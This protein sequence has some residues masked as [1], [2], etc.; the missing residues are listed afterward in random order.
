MNTDSRFY[1]SDEAKGK[2]KHGAPLKNGGF[3]ITFIYRKD[4]KDIVFRSLYLPDV[5]I[6][7][8]REEEIISTSAAS[9]MVC[10]LSRLSNEATKDELVALRYAVL[11]WLVSYQYVQFWNAKI[12]K[13]IDCELC[14]VLKGFSSL[15]LEDVQYE[16]VVINLPE[17][18][19]RNSLFPSNLL[20]E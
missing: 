13:E 17:S 5:S 1:V 9:D 11:S 19:Y 20:K 12:L 4:K 16:N 2:M 15:Q 6:I 8:L 10:A 7:S 18:I 3:H 14:S